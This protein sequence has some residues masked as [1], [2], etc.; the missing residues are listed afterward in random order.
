M[1]TILLTGAAGGVGTA[2]R[3]ELAGRY[4][5]RLSDVAPIADPSPEETVAPADLADFDAVRRAVDG[6]DGVIHLGAFGVEGPWEVIRDANI[7]GTYNLYE[8][9]KQAGVPRVVFASSNHACGFYERSRTIDH[10]C[11][12]LPDSRYGVS[13]VFGESLAALYAHKYG[14]GS[15]CIRIGNVAPKP[16]DVRR[17]SIWISHRD[18]AQLVG[19]GL[20]HP[21]IA[22]E[23]VYGM[24]D[25]ARAWW[26][27]ANAYRLGYAP[28]DRGEDYADEV[29]AAHPAETGDALIDRS[30]GGTF[31]RAELGGDPSKQDPK[32]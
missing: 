31:V 23:I 24:S 21:E 30:Q 22:F 1:K 15:L 8:A 25:N 14:V 17:L 11:Y 4:R 18:L 5:L 6:V 32:L 20:D 7:T 16:L 13:K 26:D 3:A 19:I 10:T 27:N 28:Q 9:A 12:P 2:L 29:L